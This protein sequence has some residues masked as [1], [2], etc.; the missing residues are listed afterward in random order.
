M[1]LNSTLVQVEDLAN[2]RLKAI[3]RENVEA[4]AAAVAGSSIWEE[5]DR[6]L[7]EHTERIKVLRKEMKVRPNL[8]YDCVPLPSSSMCWHDSQHIQFS[9]MLYQALI[10]SCLTVRISTPRYLSNP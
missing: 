5:A 2:G 4:E 3:E 7:R 10:A 9:A 1:N 6:V 8:V